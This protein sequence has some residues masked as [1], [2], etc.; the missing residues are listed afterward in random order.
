ME[1]L[2]DIETSFWS[3]SISSRWVMSVKCY[4][5][6]PPLHH[7]WEWGR[8]KKE[9]SRACGGM[10]GLSWQRNPPVVSTEDRD[11]Q[12]KTN[13]EYALHSCQLLGRSYFFMARDV[14]TRRAANPSEMESE[15]PTW[16]SMSQCSAASPL[17]ASNPPSASLTCPWIP[18]TW[19]SDRS[20][21]VLKFQN[22][23]I[24]WWNSIG[25]A[26]T[27]TAHQ[28]YNSSREL[29]V[30]FKIWEYLC[31]VSGERDGGKC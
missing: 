25:P 27:W 23:M 5:H 10:K 31:S 22:S 29:P 16:P 3:M 15:T 24:L 30:V 18:A 6:R 17:T 1:S 28:M 11:C 20:L 4:P 12:V 2:L 14:R 13:P 21:L 7:G 9:E 8:Q 26:L 19:F